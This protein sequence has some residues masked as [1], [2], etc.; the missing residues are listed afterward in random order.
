MMLSTSKLLLCAA[1]AI[2]VC[3][4][5]VCQA[6]VVP[7]SASELDH[8]WG[9]Q[10]CGVCCSLNAGPLCTYRGNRAPNPNGVP[11]G[12]ACG[13]TV[14]PLGR[15][16][17]NNPNIMCGWISTAGPWAH[18]TCS[19]PKPAGT[20]TLKVGGCVYVDRYVCVNHL[21]QCTCDFTYG[22]YLMDLRW[23]CGQAFGDTPC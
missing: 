9:G 18:D 17:C 12:N 3:F 5:P 19:T 2:P 16:T 11:P 7:M 4:L 13:Y 10:V 23:Y 21:E 22:N 8:T 6:S 20:C 15:S 1:L 14:L